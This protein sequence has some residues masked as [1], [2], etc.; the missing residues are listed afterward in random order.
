MTQTYLDWQQRPFNL[1]IQIE[2][3]WNN[4]KL[5]QNSNWGRYNGDKSYNLCHINE[6]LLLK[7]IVSKQEH[8]KHFFILDIGAGNF[9]FADALSQAILDDVDISSEINFHIISLRGEM[10]V[11]PEYTQVGKCHMYYLGHI[12]IENLGYELK[13][14]GLNLKHQIDIIV[15][16]WSLRHLAD[17]LG[18]FLQAYELLKP[19]TGLMLF[20]EFYFLRNHQ[21]KHWHQ[22]Q[23][24]LSL[25]WETQTPFLMFQPADHQ[26]PSHFIIKK[27]SSSPLQLNWSYQDIEL[28]ACCYDIASLTVTR[29]NS[30]NFKEVAL[31]KTP[32]M[33]LSG[34]LNLYHELKNTNCLNQSLSFFSRLDTTISKQNEVCQL[35]Q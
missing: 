14:H 6:F 25:L 24:L 20:D 31:E 9:Q 17:P 16:R 19:Q 4:I 8:A 26:L 3:A 23:S 27:P 35:H 1:Q 21:L 7:S 22:S 15:S 11:Y 5:N 13:K 18:T 29:F 32:S 30:P 12:Q 33:H 34:D 2:Y 28:I 10:P